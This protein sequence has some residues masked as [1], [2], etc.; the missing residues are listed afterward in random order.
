MNI[1]TYDAETT[2]FKHKPECKPSEKIGEAFCKPNK[3]VMH[4]LKWYGHD[5]YA[6]DDSEA[7]TKHI[8]EQIDKAKIVVGFNIKFDLH[9]LRRVGVDISHITIWDCQLAE[10]IL[11]RQSIKGQNSLADACVRRGLPKKSDVIKNDYW[12]KGID[13]D[14]I[15]W[16]VLEE[17]GLNDV[18]ITE[19][20]MKAQWYDFKGTYLE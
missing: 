8:Q 6:L 4:C 2:I 18:F 13:T 7:N 16:G 1:L 5:P 14:A 17:Y 20:L 12:D 11:N 19:E 9:W 10:W 3:L 15:S